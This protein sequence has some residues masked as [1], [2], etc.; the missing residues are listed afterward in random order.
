MLVSQDHGF[1]CLDGCRASLPDLPFSIRV[2]FE[3][4][5]HTVT[6]SLGHQGGCGNGEDG[7]VLSLACEALEW[8]ETTALTQ[9]RS[10]SFLL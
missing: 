3:S 2:P 5:F 10:V 8:P 9:A 1:Y 6:L 7:Q 4:I